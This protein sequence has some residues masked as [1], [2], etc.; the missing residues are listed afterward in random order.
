MLEDKYNKCL[1]LHEILEDKFDKLF[2]LYHSFSG[3]EL[4]KVDVAYITQ[5]LT[6]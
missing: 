5:V 2:T 3:A 1:F 4:Y 6:A